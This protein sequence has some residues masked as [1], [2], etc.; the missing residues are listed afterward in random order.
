MT[1]LCISGSRADYGYIKPVALALGAELFSIPASSAP[2]ADS[3]DGI[4]SA[5]LVFCMRTSEKIEALKPRMLVVVGDRWEILSA[6]QAAVLAGVPIAHIGAGEE[7]RG[8]Y[9]DRFRAA[10][11]ALADLHFCLTN[12]A[13]ARRMGD[14]I[15]AGCTSVTPPATLAEPDGSA[16]LA[17]YPETRGERLW[18]LVEPIERMLGARKLT[19]TVIGSNP[20]VGASMFGGHHLPLEEFHARL[21]RAS[22]IVGNSSAGI[23]EAPIL[24]T[25]SVNIGT[26]QD[27]RPFAASCFQSSAALDDIEAAIDAALRFGKQRVDSPYY[28]PNAAQTIAD[29]IRHYLEERNDDQTA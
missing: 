1:I 8:S 14:G 21:A 28:R 22:V 23:I 26:R 24:G 5:S 29:G 20:D 25:P 10:I 7:T 27:G 9:D 17:L 19:V 3:P 6:C 15:L 12:R 18:H 16:I 2:A 13:F 4:T 11:E